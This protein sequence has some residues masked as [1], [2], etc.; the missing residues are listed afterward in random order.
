MCGFAPTLS[1]MNPCITRLGDISFNFP[2]HTWTNAI[3][4][5]ITP[6]STVAVTL[7]TLNFSKGS[8]ALYIPLQVRYSTPSKFHNNNH[9]SPLSDGTG[10]CAAYLNPDYV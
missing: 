4:L 1:L 3:P 8:L 7:N 9:Y 10:P 5:K 2:A 6:T